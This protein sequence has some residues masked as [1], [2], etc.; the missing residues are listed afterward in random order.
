M[1]GIAELSP[2]ARS[3]PDLV[4]ALVDAPP[5]FPELDRGAK[6]VTTGVGGSAAPA[7]YLAWLLREA[8]GVDARFHHLSRFV[9]GA[10]PGDALVVFSQYLSPNARIAIRRAGTYGR[11]CVFTSSSAAVEGA[12]SS[13]ARVTLPP[14]S[15]GG[16]L[17]RI[18]GPSLAMCA[19]AAATRAWG[20]RLDLSGLPEMYA[21]AARAPAA[22]LDDAI[23]ARAARGQ[24]PVAVVTGAADGGVARGARWKLLEGWS[25]LEPA[26]YDVL[27]IAHGPFQAA[28]GG[29]LL[30]LALETSDAADAALFDR[31]ALVLTAEHKL[32]RLRAEGPPWRAPLEHDAATTAIML[33]GLRAAPRD[34]SW[35]S[36]GQD[37]PLYGLGE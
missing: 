32:V 8:L 30:A 27:E 20:G 4:R 7:R 2:R 34:V 26:G 13:V 25:I 35:S 12:P 19:A 29:E 5:T 18:V 3:L 15:E 14:P 36:S 6:V 28:R 9:E 1:D 11:A 33:A 22:G 16:T 17:V 21:A 31:L 24:T 10:P 37:A 23:L